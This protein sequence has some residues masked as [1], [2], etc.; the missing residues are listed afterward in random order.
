MSAILVVPDFGLGEQI[1]DN[2]QRLK[3]IVFTINNYTDEDVELLKNLEEIV[4]CMIAAKEVGES[5]TPHIQGYAELQSA[6]TR[7]AL[8][9]KYLP[10]AWI[11]KARGDGKQNF[12][13]CKKG[14]QSK[15]EWT[16]DGVDGRH[17]G[18][19][20]DLVLEVGVPVGAGKRTDIDRAVEDLKDGMSFKEACIEHANVAMKYPNGFKMVRSALVQ[21][22]DEKPEVIVRWGATGTGKTHCAML[23]DWPEERSYVWDPSLK[24][25][26]VVWFDGY[27]YEKKVVLE[28]FR[29]GSMPYAQMLRL[30]D[31]Y[32]AKVQVKGFVTEFVATKI[33]ITSPFHP[34]RWFPNL[35]KGDGVEQLLRRIDKI[36][37][38]VTCDGEEMAR[39]LEEGVD[40]DAPCFTVGE[41]N[42]KQHALEKQFGT[43]GF[44]PGASFP[45]WQ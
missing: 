3:S 20:V 37:H 32:E 44:Y 36:Y 39:I 29:A 26:N 34:K 2:K 42:A 35:E 30:L 45:T 28:E 16:R 40:E 31:R 15:E 33:V 13:Y 9:K 41:Q 11:G 1:V 7:S 10:R 17:Y 18:D 25:S 4:R 8:A 43:E 14:R 22:R 23:V 6:K 38:H 24:G 27:D 5:E 19:E 12:A 21:P